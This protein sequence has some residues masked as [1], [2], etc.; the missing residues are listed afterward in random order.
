MSKY[1]FFISGAQ[2]DLKAEPRAL[3][4]YVI[5]DVL[6]SEYIDIFLFEDPP[7]KS[8]PQCR[9]TVGLERGICR[10]VNEV[11]RPFKEEYA[12]NSR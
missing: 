7:A 11:Q 9:D 2:K 8:G 5:D 10:S 1:K 3:K 4:D 12:C 6:N